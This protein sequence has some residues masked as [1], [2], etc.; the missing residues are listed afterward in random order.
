MR[1]TH[2]R[3]PDRTAERRGKSLIPSSRIEIEESSNERDERSE[4]TEVARE[5]A[6]D[7][8]GV[9]CVPVAIIAALLLAWWRGLNT[10]F[11]E[12]YTYT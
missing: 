5:T 8:D 4:E 7:K 10:A 12:S 2:T 3:V 11:L 6:D 9:T 1:R